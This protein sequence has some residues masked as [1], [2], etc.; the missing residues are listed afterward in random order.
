MWHKN[1]AH[2]SDNL[3][4]FDA[5]ICI[6]I[7][8]QAFFG[9]ISHRIEQISLPNKSFVVALWNIV[10]FT[11]KLFCV[12]LFGMWYCVY[13][14]CQNANST[15]GHWRSK[16]KIR[17]SKQI[18]ILFAW[19]RFK[20]NRFIGCGRVYRENHIKSISPIL[21][22]TKTHIRTHDTYPKKLYWAVHLNSEQNNISILV[23]WMLMFIRA[24][25]IYA[26]IC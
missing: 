13:V 12:C 4:F 20:Y 18:W 6:S 7:D 5:F 9:W 2:K 10:S 17:S 3:L 19:L 25:C 1:F 15:V 24:E 26:E 21:S 23:V 8:L 22:S 14:V 11:N 16:K